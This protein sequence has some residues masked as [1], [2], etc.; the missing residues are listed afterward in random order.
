MRQGEIRE[1]TRRSHVCRKN[2]RLSSAW[3]TKYG[4]LSSE[5]RDG[6]WITSQLPS[7]AETNEDY[8]L[9][10]FG[11]NE[12]EEMHTALQDCVR[13]C[14][15]IYALAGENWHEKQKITPSIIEKTLLRCVQ[16]VPF[17]AIYT[18]KNAWIVLCKGEFFRLSEE[19][20][21]NL[22]LL[23]LRFFWHEATKEG[24]FSNEEWIWQKANAR[25]FDIPLLSLSDAI[26]WDDVTKKLTS[27]SADSLLYLT[28]DPPPSHPLK[29]LWFPASHQ[30]HEALKK[31]AQAGTEIVWDETKKLPQILIEDDD[32]EIFF[33][34]KKGRLRIR[35]TQEQ[36]DDFTRLLEEDARWYFHTDVCLGSPAHQTSYFWLSDTPSPALLITEQPI[37]ITSSVV[38]SSLRTLN[39]TE[40]LSF[41]PPHSL[42]LSVVYTWTVEP[43]RI[44]KGSQKDPLY[45]KWEQFDKAWQARLKK[46]EEH[47]TLLPKDSSSPL[48]KAISWFGNALLG[49]QKKEEEILSRIEKIKSYLP[50]KGS[51][52]ETHT[53]IEEL[54]KMEEEAASLLKDIEEK[55]HKAQEEAEEQKQREEHDLAI[56]VFQKQLQEEHSQLEEKDQELQKTKEELKKIDSPFH[57]DEQTN[58]QSQKNKLLYDQKN[59]EKK[60]KEIRAK[61]EKLQAEIKKPFQFSHSKEIKS[62]KFTERAQHSSLSSEKTSKFSLPEVPEET[63]PALGELRLHHDRRYLVIEKWEEL[64]MGEKEAERLRAHIVTLEKK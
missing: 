59:T 44:P 42:A 49:F 25:P 63:L 6:E 7:T 58:T 16:E 52:E 1:I 45:K 29:R 37:S 5:N 40:P 19:Q 14:S 39:E 2:E 50:S 33:V 46:L 53:Q 34:G 13:S 56:E 26:R 54:C 11:S 31:L 32:G 51:T 30:H 3:I 21:E 23:F 4:F 22:R 35:L 38:A 28:E 12:T 55:N 60:I 27:K 47:L 43:P 15:R 20:A 62:P 24:Y 57:K 18:K 64:E 17:S 48:S 61:I 8:A 9:L 36:I 10:F 41:P